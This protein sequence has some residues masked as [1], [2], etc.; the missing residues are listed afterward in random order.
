MQ[1]Y[2]ENN[3]LTSHMVKNQDQMTDMQFKII[4]LI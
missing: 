2:S 3:L 1:E 4:I